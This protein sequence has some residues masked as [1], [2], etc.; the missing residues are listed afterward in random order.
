MRRVTLPAIKLPPPPWEHGQTD[1]HFQRMTLCLRCTSLCA[2]Q[3]REDANCQDSWEVKIVTYNDGFG[4]LISRFDDSFTTSLALRCFWSLFS[5]SSSTSSGIS[6][7]ACSRMTG[8]AA[9]V[10]VKS[11][12]CSI[13]SHSS[14]PFNA[15]ESTH[16]RLTSERY[17][18]AARNT[19]S[20]KFQDHVECSF[21][22]IKIRNHQSTTRIE[23][24]KTHTIYIKCDKVLKEARY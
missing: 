20:S 3:S 15:C 22:C 6:T 21:N 17:F 10:S 4:C 16:N 1:F 5:C 7:K 11:I 9:T 19:S 12:R 2:T 13:T 23:F 24:V 8:S 18:E 14:N